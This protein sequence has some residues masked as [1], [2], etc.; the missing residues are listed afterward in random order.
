MPHYLS[1]KNELCLLGKIVMSGTRIVIPQSLK[2]E[3]LLLEH[4]G[5]EGI[6]KTKTRMRI[7][8]WWPK[9]DHDAAPP[10]SC[11]HTSC[12]SAFVSNHDL[13][14]PYPLS[15]LPWEENLLV[16]VDYFSRFFEENIMRST[17]SQKMIEALT[18]IF[19][20][21]MDIQLSLKSDNAPQFVS[22]E[23]ENFVATH[24][25]QHPK[26]PPL[27]LKLMAK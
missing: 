9:R 4:E 2:S 17:T 20:R 23:F 27:G 3:E 7:K 11:Q 13:L 22:E 1:V 18:P 19:R 15:S 5:H 25:I 21:G 26:S 6:V 12:V 10:L 14:L 24:G 16:V 8:I